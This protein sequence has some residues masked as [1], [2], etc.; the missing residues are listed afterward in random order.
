MATLEV[1]CLKTYFYQNSSVTKAVDGPSFDIRE[2]EIFGL[3]GES[4]AGKTLTGRSILRLVPKPGKI[5][6]E[7]RFKGRNLLSLSEKEIRKIRGKD[8]SAIPQ[9]PLSSLNPAFK[10]EDQMVDVL[11]LHL[12]LSKQ[13]SKHRSEV[14]LHQV[15]IA[16]PHSVLNKY[17]HQLSGGMSQRVMIAIAFSCE[18]TLVIADEPT[19]ALD[20][21]TQLQ[22]IDLMRRTQ[23]THGTAILFVTHNLWL[24]ARICS[25]IG[26]MYAGRL[27]ENA[28][29]EKLFES[30]RHPYT[31]ALL[32]TIPRHDVKSGTL[33]IIEGSMPNLA[34][35]PV[36][37]NFAPRCPMKISRCLKRDP[38]EMK[39]DPD[40]KVS[41]FLNTES[42]KNG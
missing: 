3:V 18:P 39:I 34:N 2:K 15:G 33:P 17:P 23:E 20:V 13:E 11:R 25:R 31:Q 19:T 27:V 14:L 10:I 1:R 38:E 26:V 32:D 36:G 41:C 42:E 7:V 12:A 30:P 6:G 16:D 8:I 22:I 37:C 9:D 4:G 24:A 35:L 40:H 28:S 21:I 29:V 5:V